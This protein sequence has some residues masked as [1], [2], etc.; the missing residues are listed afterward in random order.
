[1]IAES[2]PSRIVYTVG[3]THTVVIDPPPGG[4]PD[5]SGDANVRLESVRRDSP[6]YYANVIRQIRRCFRTR[7]GGDWQ[8]TVSFVIHRDGTVSDTELVA[9]S[10]DPSF[11]FDAIGAIECAGR[12]RFGPF[13]EDLLWESLPVRFEFG[14]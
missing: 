11:D 10:G 8:S 3:R 5:Q 6:E 12:G 14:R 9:R 7:D 1:M 2:W 4:T 13:P